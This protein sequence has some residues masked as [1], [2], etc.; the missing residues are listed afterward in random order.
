MLQV[1]LVVGWSEVIGSPPLT[2]PTLVE[3]VLPLAN[4][5]CPPAKRPAAQP[6]HAEPE[7]SPSAARLPG[8]P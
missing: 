5:A 3:P 1:G 6:G 4:F 8:N 7:G 2:L